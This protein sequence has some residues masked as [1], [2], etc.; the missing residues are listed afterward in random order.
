M[1]PEP[2]RFA[3]LG[4]VRVRRAGTE[5]DLG[6]PQERALLALLLIRA[7]QPVTVSEIVDVL[8]GWDPPDTAVNVVH[9]H[10]GSLRRLLEPGLPN[11][12]TGQWLVRDAGGYRLVTDSD[13]L[14]LLRFRALRADARRAASD[15]APARSVELH[16]EALSLWQGPAATGIPAQARAHA[17]FGA[18][19]DEYLAAVKETADAALR[20]GLPDAVLPRLR[21]AAAGSP[22]DEPLL[23]RLMLALA[24]TG[25]RAEALTTYH[26]VSGRLADELGIDPGPELRDA[27]AAVLRDAAVPAAAAPGAAEARSGGGTAATGHVGPGATPLPA[28]AQLPHDLATFS[29]RRAEL[30]EVLALVS[31]DARSAETVVISAIGGMAGVGKTTLAVHWA[32]RVM[33]RYP[34]GQLYVN[35]RGFDPSGAVMSSDEAVRGF[36]DTLGVP[37]ER[38]PHGLDAQAALY[39]SVLAGRRVLVLLDNARDTEHVRPLLPGSPGCL[40]IVTSRNQLSGLVATHGAHSLNL[41]PLDTDEARELLI[42]RLGHARAAAEPEALTEITALCAGLPLALACVAA[43][44]ATHPHF[45]LS[46]IAAELREAHGSLDAFTRAETPV[47]VGAVFSWSSG[48]LTPAAARLFRLLGLHPGPDITAPAAAALAGL[49]V[50]EAQLLL[51]ELARVHL[52]NE[53]LPGR[54]AFHD[55]LRAYAAELAHTQHGEDE[56]RDAVHRLFEHYLYTAHAAGLLIAPYADGLPLPPAPAGTRPEPLADDERAQTWLTAQYAVLLSVVDA[57][58]STGA[59]RLACL[60]VSSLERFFDRQGHWYDWAAAQRTALDAAR[61]LRDTVME[62]HALRGLARA[63]GRLGLH[64]ASGAHLDRALELFTE[65]GDDVGRASVHRSLGW[66]AEQRGDLHG[67]L[68][69]DQL[70]LD[71][72]RA[73]GGQ[74][75]QA[76]A[77]N[78]VGWSYATLGDYRHAL[79]H[80]LEALA[81]LQDLG[82]RVAQ[83]ATWDSIAYAH[84]HLGDHPRALAGYRNALALYQDMGVLAEEAGSL[85]RIGDVHR[86]T[87][88]DESARAAWRSAL[89]ILTDL[90]HPDAEHVGARLRELGAS[91][92]PE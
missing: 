35:L 69:H 70:A 17:A 32:R 80:C 65:L 54:Y 3:V 24:A 5:L 49:T 13:S 29:G 15:G 75:A 77:L 6:R 50:R 31:S 78:A 42:R 60:L 91:R 71:L 25:Q 66:E 44:A 82:D 88:D 21:E 23:A 11:R 86:A 61:R 36:L 40:T 63:E 90:G 57:A 18:L 34:D 28:P 22:L 16:T 2:L 53:H 81:V 64:D 85:V 47:D 72:L 38:V 8:W 33:D 43:R 79:S 1:A 83:A 55:L 62:A 39:R 51:T 19:D 26:A 48:A 46:A 56:R 20:A 45:P 14:D 9:R 73:A 59:D 52:I 76:S 84:H 12:A 58:A 67:A 4:P 41:R 27:H 10:V 74:A 37:P 87:G 30:D 7:G 92:V 68:R 89:T